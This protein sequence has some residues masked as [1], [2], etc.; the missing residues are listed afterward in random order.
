MEIL[1]G[2]DDAMIQDCSDFYRHAYVKGLSINTILIFSKAGKCIF[3]I[4]L[5][6]VESVCL[7]SKPNLRKTYILLHR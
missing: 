5:W 3:I 6:H 7:L 2:Y 4:R 1:D